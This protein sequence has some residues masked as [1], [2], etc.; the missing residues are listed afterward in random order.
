MEKIRFGFTNALQT[1]P[2]KKHKSTQV[3]QMSSGGRSD[4]NI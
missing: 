4:S 3:V 2:I 1:K